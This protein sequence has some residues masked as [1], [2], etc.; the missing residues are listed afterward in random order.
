[1]VE[2]HKMFKA[3]YDKPQAAAS[4][5]EAMR[6]AALKVMQNPEYAHPFYWG[7]FVVIGDAS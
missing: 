5:A 4:T 1:M 3:R 7:G 6:R 2:F